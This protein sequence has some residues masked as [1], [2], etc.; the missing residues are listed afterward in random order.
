MTRQSA[1]RGLTNGLVRLSQNQAGGSHQIPLPAMQA[2]LVHCRH[3]LPNETFN[4]GPNLAEGRPS[5][6]RS[7][8]LTEADS[9]MLTWMR[10]PT[11]AFGE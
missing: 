10:R 7:S 4:S 1:D 2:L 9:Q 3:V 11:S 5:M 6:S 8:Y